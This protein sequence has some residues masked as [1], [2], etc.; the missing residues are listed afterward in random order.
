MTLLNYILI[1][2]F[3]VGCLGF[4]FTFIMWIRTLFTKDIDAMWYWNFWIL[5]IMLYI[6]IIN[7]IFQI[8]YR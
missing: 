1:G 3:G 6:N 7:L 5:G 4:V 2:L 8:T